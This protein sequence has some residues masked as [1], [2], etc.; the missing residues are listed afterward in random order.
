MC[1]KI[2]SVLTGDNKIRFTEVLME[3]KK[4]LSLEE[5]A[6]VSG[7]GKEDP[8]CEVYCTANCGFSRVFSDERAAI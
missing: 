2:V 6:S 1:G 5:L 7:G 3:D 4:T 8:T